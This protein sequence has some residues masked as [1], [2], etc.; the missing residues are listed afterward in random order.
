MMAAA[1]MLAAATAGMA[2]GERERRSPSPITPQHQSALGVCGVVNV[3]PTGTGQGD[4][5]PV[6]FANT[7]YFKVTNSANNKI[8]NAT[9]KVGIVQPPKHGKVEPVMSDGD[10]TDPRYLPE[11][12]F[13]GNDSFVLRVEG[14]GYAI[15]LHYYF[16]VTNDADVSANPSRVCKGDT[17]KISSSRNYSGSPM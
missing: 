12:G 10:M 13:L 1:G 5:F 14:S 6:L 17:W 2:H 11:D 9:A 16:Y 15:Q 7:Y 3:G 8:D 4:M